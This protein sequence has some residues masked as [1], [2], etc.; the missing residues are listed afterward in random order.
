[1]N[2]CLLAC[3]TDFAWNLILGQGHGVPYPHTPENY[4]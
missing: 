3:S 4:M 2:L 1:M